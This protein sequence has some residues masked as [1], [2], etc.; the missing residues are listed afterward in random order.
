MVDSN[1]NEDSSDDFELDYDML[2]AASQSNSMNL[3]HRPTFMKE[4]KE[5]KNDLPSLTG[6]LYKYSP[7]M[8]KSWQRR[9]VVLKDRQLKYYK[10]RSSG[11]WD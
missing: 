4:K 3:P 1:K 5:T 8:F 11:V 9:K 7:A 2:A 10:E 6:N